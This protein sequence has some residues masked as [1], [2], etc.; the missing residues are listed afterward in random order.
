MSDHELRG[1]A[2]TYV[3]DEDLDRAA[4]ERI[5]REFTACAGVH[6]LRVAFRL[7]NWSDTDFLS[8]LEWYQGLVEDQGLRDDLEQPLV[9]DHPEATEIW[10][11]TQLWL[12]WRNRDLVRESDI[13]RLTVSVHDVEQA[14]EAISI[15]A[16]ELIF[17]HVF[18]SESHPGE[19]GR[20]LDALRAAAESIQVYQ[21]PPRLTAIGG[22]DEYTIPEIGG[23]RHHSVAAM[24]TISRSSNIAQTLDRIRGNWVA[25]R[26]NADLD[27][28]QRTPFGRPSSL[29]F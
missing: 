20:G 3:T 4:H 11:D 25:A 14:H 13:G 7:P 27:E 2:F 24:R 1:P 6:P 8:L 26:I 9:H 21:N 22:I 17:G 19:P 29:F 23:Y 15:G 18:S 12:P 28:S 10:P 5:L 16:S